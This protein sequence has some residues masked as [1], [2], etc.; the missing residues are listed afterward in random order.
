[1]HDLFSPKFASLYETYRNQDR[2]DSVERIHLQSTDGAIPQEL[3]RGYPLVFA[4]QVFPKKSELDVIDLLEIHCPELRIQVRRPSFDSPN[5]YL[6]ERE[7]EEITMADYL[8]AL[9]TTNNEQRTTV[10]SQVRGEPEATF[11]DGA[12]TKDVS[13][14]SRCSHGATSVLVGWS[15]QRNTASQRLD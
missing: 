7:V 5:Q 15:G 13:T 10:N 12:A 14:D 2:I 8:R 9:R 6:T 11:I 3:L 4:N 1:M